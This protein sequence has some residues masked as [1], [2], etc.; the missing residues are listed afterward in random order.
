VGVILGTAA[1]MSPEQARGKPVDKRADIWAYGA[2]LYEMLTGQRPFSGSDVTDTLASV[3]R[4]APDWDALPVSTPR[5]IR[6]LLRRCLEKTPERRLRDI[7]DARLDL[8][9]GSA[10]DHAR[11][12]APAG[13][14]AGVSTL[15]RG[16]ILLGVGMAAAALGAGITAVIMLTR[17]P[18]ATGEV[19]RS[20]IVVPALAYG[21]RD[22]LVALSPDGTTLVYAAPGRLYRRELSQ[23]STQPIPGTEGASQPFFSPDGRWIGFVD[24]IGNLRK[25]SS[26][27]EAPITILSWPQ[28][29]IQGG[30][31]WG[32]DGQI[33]VSRFLDGLYSVSADGGTPEPVTAL[34][35]DDVWHVGPR[36]L[37]DGDAA[38]FAVVDAQGGSHVAVVSLDT[39][40]NHRLVAGSSPRY[41][42]SEHLVF[43]RDAT[44]W[45][46]P[47]DAKRLALTGDPVAVLEDVGFYLGTAHFAVA[48]PTGSL[49]YTR[50]S[51]VKTELR[52]LDR[53]G[54]QLEV[55]GAIDG[56]IRTFELDRDD[57]LLA[58]NSPTPTGDLWLYDTE[59]DV[60]TQLLGVGVDPNWSPDGRRVAYAEG[61]YGRISAIPSDGGPPTV[62]YQREGKQVWLDDW[63][64]VGDR[65][66]VHLQG[67][68]NQ[69]VV[70]SSQGDS[71]PIVFDEA[72]GLDQIEFSPDGRWI[73]YNAN[74]GA[75]Q[76][77][78]VVPYPP[79]G[80]R[81]QVSSGGGVQPQ[82]RPDGKELFYLS[83][84]G[85]LMAVSVD[86]TTGFRPGRP[87]PLFQTGLAV[88]SQVEQYAVSSDG[89]RFLLPTPVGA[90][91][92]S[93]VLV[94]NWFQELNRLV[95]VD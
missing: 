11:E 74:H 33:L 93:L 49:V 81:I 39:G 69:G 59:R 15:G 91:V 52:W 5:S 34:G 43:S 57:R 38:L 68:R 14:Q 29:Q 67:P 56:L 30:P 21:S 76:E 9:E 4:S 12:A 73:A 41:L 42:S 32:K 77:V 2:V 72:D 48:G 47:F 78:Y 60:T 22:P 55:A 54:V 95:P 28:Q 26:G 65:L 75:G 82:W 19:V 13:A 62:L 64:K 46:A 7:G 3:L 17:P 18:V 23:L 63:T 94:Q 45:A 88:D 86:T 61:F 66:A 40:E 35:A 10:E 92:A 79:T 53:S 80:E 83:F 87:T 20:S 24:R 58:F 31:S 1:Y 50:R 89:S 44:L 37:P 85:A 6:R 70:V 27:G 90:S 84:A 51:D 25:V 16:R 36:H 71:E 8:E